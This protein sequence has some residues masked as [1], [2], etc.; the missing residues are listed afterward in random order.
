MAHANIPHLKYTGTHQQTITV[1]V[2]PAIAAKWLATANTDN[3]HITKNHVKYLAGMMKKGEWF[4]EGKDA[5]GF[6]KEGRLIDGQ[7]RLMAIV[8]SQVTL[9]LNVVVNLPSESQKYL[10][11]GR[12]RSVSDRS[13]RSSNV[14]SLLSFIN[15]TKCDMA[16]KNWKSGRTGADKMTLETSDKLY[17]KHRKAINNICKYNG[18]PRTLR[19]VN[20]S[21]MRAAFLPLGQAG[22]SE[23]DLWFG[24][25]H[26][27]LG[28]VKNSPAAA[29][30]N[31]IFEN[32]K[33]VGTQG[34]L[35]FLAARQAIE[36]FL[37][38]E[39]LPRITAVEE[40]TKESNKDALVS[41]SDHVKALT[42]KND[43]ESKRN[44][45]DEESPNRKRNTPI[46]EVR[47]RRKPKKSTPKQAKVGTGPRL[48]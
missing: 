24:M 11:L 32:Q 25:F 39:E 37:A 16:R 1:K 6:S 38:D 34:Y 5:L 27:G 33:T 44:K 48:G 4:E 15:Y 31:W 13:G 7:H 2:T 36:A 12:G 29:L 10:D 22:I 45:L 23:C 28:L 9:K 21:A 43:R 26:E 47:E 19:W 18:N 20:A 14:E 35:V 30:R 41:V 8:K 40:F 46:R 3:R 42:L 17:R